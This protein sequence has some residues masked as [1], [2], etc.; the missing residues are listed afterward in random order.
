MF[1]SD[2]VNTDTFLCRS[3]RQPIF[4]LFDVSQ[5]GG[6]GRTMSLA[7]KCANRSCGAQENRVVMPTMNEQA[8]TGQPVTPLSGQQLPENMLLCGNPSVPISK[9]APDGVCRGNVFRVLE[10]GNELLSRCAVCGKG[11]SLGMIN[12]AI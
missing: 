7:M 9:H 6:D 11:D 5:A 1:G 10:R 3:C 2:T 12:P 4:W 8:D